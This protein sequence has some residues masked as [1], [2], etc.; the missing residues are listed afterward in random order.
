M[1]RI[2]KRLEK[3]KRPGSVRPADF[4]SKSLGALLSERKNFGQTER[5]SRALTLIRVVRMVKIV[6]QCNKVGHKAKNDEEHENEAQNDRSRPLHLVDGPG[7][8]RRHLV[9]HGSIRLTI[10]FHL[11][12]RELLQI[13]RFNYNC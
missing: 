4:D 10:E 1:K 11:K 12:T 7:L 5:W 2:S 9:G 3:A 6:G 8:S 13:Q